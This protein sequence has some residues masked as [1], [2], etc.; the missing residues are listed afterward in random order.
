METK[1]SVERFL[2]NRNI[3]DGVAI[4]LDKAIG[5]TATKIDHHSFDTKIYREV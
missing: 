5:A 4:Q 1:N 2:K 3:T